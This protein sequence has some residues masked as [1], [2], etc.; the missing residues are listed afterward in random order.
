MQ[1][2]GWHGLRVTT[3][4][5]LSNVQQY[6]ELNHLLT[7]PPNSTQSPFGLGGSKK[8]SH[9]F[10]RDP[11]SCYDSAKTR[12]YVLQSR[13]ATSFPMIGMEYGCLPSRWTRKPGHFIS[14][15]ACEL[16]P[17][18]IGNVMGSSKLGPSFVLHSS[19][20][21][22]SLLFLGGVLKS[23]PTITGFSSDQEYSNFWKQFQG[24]NH[25]DA[26]GNLTNPADAAFL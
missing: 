19:I 17:I 12:L 16:A 6:S 26:R 22:S 3:H 11:A 4:P 5:V 10:E 21:L 1:P 9:P 20:S 8:R 23:G 18:S 24:L 13:Y 14:R 25:L 15:S 7:N 2:I